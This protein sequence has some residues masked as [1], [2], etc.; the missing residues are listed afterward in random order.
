MFSML[1]DDATTQAATFGDDGIAMVMGPGHDPC[2]LQPRCRSI[3]PD[4]FAMDM[5]NGGKPM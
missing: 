2:L 1:F 3:R 4:V 5:P